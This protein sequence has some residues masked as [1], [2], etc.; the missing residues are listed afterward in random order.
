[1]NVSLDRQCGDSFDLTLGKKDVVSFY[2]ELESGHQ[3]EHESDGTV[4]GRSFTLRWENL[5]GQVKQE[6]LFNV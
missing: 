2:C 4:A 6:S 3:G 5:A 1:M